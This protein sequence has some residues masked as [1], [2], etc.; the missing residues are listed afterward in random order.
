MLSKKIQNM[1]VEERSAYFKAIRAKVKN[2]G[3]GN[4]YFAVLKR[5]GRL[6]ELKTIQSKGGANK[7]K[8]E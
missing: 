4:S 2:P 8:S 6:D 1:S 7:P 5:E 3:G